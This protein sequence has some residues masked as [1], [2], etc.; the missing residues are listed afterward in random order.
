[1]ASAFPNKIFVGPTP[2]TLTEPILLSYFSRF[3]TIVA[4]EL[5]SEEVTKPQRTLETV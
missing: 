5:V 3:G 1:M 4:L 2:T